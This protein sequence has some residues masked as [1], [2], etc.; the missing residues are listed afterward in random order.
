LDKLTYRIIG[1]AITVHKELGPGLY[2]KVYEK[3]LEKEQKD[4]EMKVESQQSVPVI[5]KGFLLIA[6][7][8]MTYWRRT[9]SW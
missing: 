5:Y 6:K 4:Q 7:F 8:A 1:A 2:E 3:C 9:V